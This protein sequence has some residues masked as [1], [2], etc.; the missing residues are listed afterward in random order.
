VMHTFIVSNNQR[1]GQPT[2]SSGLPS[3]QIY[4]GC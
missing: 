4:F 2:V 1:M 3:A